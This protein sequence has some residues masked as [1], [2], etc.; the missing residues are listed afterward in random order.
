L[1]SRTQ[2]EKDKQEN[3][4]RL[5]ATGLEKISIHQVITTTNPRVIEKLVSHYKQAKPIRK[6]CVSVVL[7]QSK[8]K[9]S[10]KKREKGIIVITQGEKGEF[11]SKYSCF[12]SFAKEKLVTWCFFA[13]P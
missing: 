9:Q 1:C 12:I 10:G 3:S 8:A 5:S 7:L 2:H 6:E 11:A 4:F 13:C